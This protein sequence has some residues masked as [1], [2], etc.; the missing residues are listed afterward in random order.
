MIPSTSV[1]VVIDAQNGFVTENSAHA[2]EAIRDLVKRWEAAGGAVVFTR[3]L[4][5]PGSPFERIIN[6]KELHTSPEIDIVDELDP[7]AARAIVLDK[8][9]YSLFT[10]DGA[11]LVR[12]YRWTD[13]YICGLDTESCVLKTAVDA[14]ERGL[15][16][17]IVADAVASHAG[18][19][20]HDA[21]LIVAR[22]MLGA[23]QIITRTRLDAELSPAS[24]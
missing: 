20:A 15:T 10:D 17:W 4:N 12:E 19:V 21:G 18:P 5:Y 14:F 11:A 3:Y 9:I 16:P 6:W 2:V 22:R 8:G 13:L 23:R 24:A 7:Y 1:L